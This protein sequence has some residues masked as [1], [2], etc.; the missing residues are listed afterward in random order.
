MTMR[1]FGILFSI[2]SIFLWS[3]KSQK[4]EQSNAPIMLSISKTPCFG[5]CEIYDL[6]IYED[7][8][9]EINKK[10]FIDPIGQFSLTLKKK[11]ILQISELANKINLCK[12]DSLYGNNIADLP[13][14]I[15]TFNCNG[16][17]K[18]TIATMGY[19]QELN[20]LIDHINQIVKREDWQPLVVD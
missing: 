5:S 3:C 10:R 7:G 14:T 13:S 2:I 12:M 15:I 16:K 17:Y 20:L 19:P 6:T 1:T 11:E 18:T 4:V 8:K 9:A